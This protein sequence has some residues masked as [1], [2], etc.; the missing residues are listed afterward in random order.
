MTSDIFKNKELL[1]KKF[2]SNHFCNFRR[3]KEINEK[4][5][6]SSNVRLKKLNICNYIFDSK[7]IAFIKLSKEYNMFSFILLYLT[8]N[9]LNT[10]K[11]NFDYFAKKSS[12]KV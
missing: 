11:H 5:T 6:R 1:L 4:L 7:H 10:L 9:F 2:Y 12:F 8:C 3:V